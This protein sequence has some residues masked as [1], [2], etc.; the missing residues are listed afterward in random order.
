[1]E[2]LELTLRIATGGWIRIGCL[3]STGPGADRQLE[4]PAVLELLSRSLTRLQYPSPK[5]WADSYLAAFALASRLTVVTFD[6]TLQNN[7]EDAAL[8][9]PW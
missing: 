6:S 1:M 2:A 5:D 4:E 3:V 9:K 7:T 8:L